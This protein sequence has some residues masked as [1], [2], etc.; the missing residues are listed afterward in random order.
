MSNDTTILGT[1]S[2]ATLTEAGATQ[3]ATEQ[4]GTPAGQTR[5]AADEAN[6]NY[7]DTVIEAGV[8]LRFGLFQGR[9][10]KGEDSHADDVLD[11]Q[12]IRRMAADV[13]PGV[14]DDETIGSNVFQQGSAIINEV[15]DPEEAEKRVDALAAR[16]KE[17][18]KAL[19]LCNTKR[20]TF[21]DNIPALQFGMAYIGFGGKKK[22]V[23]VTMMNAPLVKRQSAGQ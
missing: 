21:R 17:K 14:I 3:V 16:L 20:V 6:A 15:T 8:T 19:R 2:P 18:L 12:I 23:A 13:A 11:A 5:T 7:A 10:K 9:A 22:D 4:A 1:E